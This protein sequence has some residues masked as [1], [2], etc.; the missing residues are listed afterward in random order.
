[1]KGGELFAELERGAM[2]PGKLRIWWQGQISYAL[3]GFAGTVLIDPFLI[4]MERR[5]VKPPFSPDDVQALDAILVTHEHS[6]HFDKDFIVE[7]MEKFPELR[8][9][10][11]APL[12]ELFV[13]KT[14]HTDRLVPAQPGDVLA[15]GSLKVY[16][17]PAKHGVGMTDAYTYGREMSGGLYRY[18]G[19]IVDMGGAT[20]FHSGDALVSEE[21][22][23]A[24][25]AFPKPI[26]IALLPINGR[27]YFREKANLVGNMDA[28][29]AAALAACIHAD[30]VIPG[31]YDMFTDN[32]GFPGHFV[33]M[34]DRFHP[35]LHAA[36]LSRQRIF[37]Y[38]APERE[39]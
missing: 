9:V 2:T 34:I 36:I 39:S 8:V 27:D 22:V 23:E 12:A 38:C 28:R 13:G 21:L 11:P 31:H 6:D 35:D 4:P 30:L 1:M 5:L 7:A 17:V 20:V 14:P 3:R 18:L 25:L 10:L 29:E 16:P 15:F 26:D 19:Y 37:T 32:A 33:E 24:L